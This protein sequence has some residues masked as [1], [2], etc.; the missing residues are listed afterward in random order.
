MNNAAK[1]VIRIRRLEFKSCLT[2]V[3]RALDHKY[4]YY[5]LFLLLLLVQ[6]HSHPFHVSNPPPFIAQFVLSL[7]LFPPFFHSEKQ[8]KQYP[9]SLS[10]LS[11][12]PHTPL[13]HC[14]CRASLSVSQTLY[15]IARVF[16][17]IFLVELSHP[18]HE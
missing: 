14:F 3:S 15:Y 1:R 18:T 4:Y 17:D 16:G 13:C 10:S 5:F 2:S 7:F 8:N 9:L 12:F 11:S 6:G